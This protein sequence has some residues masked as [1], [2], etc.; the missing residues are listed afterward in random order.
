MKRLALGLLSVLV[1]GWTSLGGS[2]F[3]SGNTQTR[4]DFMSSVRRSE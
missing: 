4:I 2:N 1:V 3:R